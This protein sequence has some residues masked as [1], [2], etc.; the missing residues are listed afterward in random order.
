[1]SVV[2][3]QKI[4]PRHSAIRKRPETREEKMIN[5]LSP[6]LNLMV[7]AVRY[8]SSSLLRDF[9]EVSHL[10]LSKKGPGDFVSSADLMVEKK[11]VSFLQD[12]KPDYG[13][14]SEECGSIAPKNDSP[15]CW[16]IDPVDGTTNFIH[17]L[18]TFSISLALMRGDDVLDAVIFNP[19][20]NELYYAEKGQGAFVMRPTGDERLRVSS[21]RNMEMTI[22]SINPA[23]LLNHPKVV[24]AF[25]KDNSAVRINGS[26]TL[27]MAS[28]AAGQSDVFLENR[29]HLWDIAT[30]YL[31]VKEA[32]GIVQTWSGK[33]SFKDIVKEGAF[34]ATTMDLCDEILKKLPKSKKNLQKK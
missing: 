7:K 31:L 34:M 29:V 25:L 3:H 8:A 4:T 27:A 22:T 19:V 30:G 18:P 2:M 11:L 24:E 26:T 20:L 5:S 9:H 15:Y 17:A 10:Q 32:G 33:T 16:V 13:I 14:L 12:A 23:F 1:M 6:I 28:V 21:R